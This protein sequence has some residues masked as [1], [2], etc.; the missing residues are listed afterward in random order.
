M[1]CWSGGTVD[2]FIGG[3]GGQTFYAVF[4]SNTDTVGPVQNQIIMHDMF[5]PGIAILPNGNPF[6]VAGSAGGDGGLSSSTWTGSSFTAGPKLNIKRGY[7]SAL[8]L[9]NG[10][11]C[12]FHHNM[13]CGIPC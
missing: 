3:A 2:D 5:C 6:V 13:C 12:S 4:D 8:T 1:V 9:A 10:E 11:A 7:N